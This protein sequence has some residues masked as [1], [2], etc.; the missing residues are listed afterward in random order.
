MKPLVFDS[1]PQM[2]ELLN[3]IREILMV[4]GIEHAQEVLCLH[5]LTLN[6][7]VELVTLSHV[8][9]INYRVCLNFSLAYRTI[10][11]VL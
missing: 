4:K 2:N 6:L 11:F 3:L 7:E 10:I 8:L 9:L 1:I 5:F